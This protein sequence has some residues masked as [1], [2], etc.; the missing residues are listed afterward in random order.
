MTTYAV[1]IE[2]DV[3][4]VAREAGL[5]GLR[6]RIVPAIRGMPGF[7][8]G[9]WLTGNEAGTGSPSREAGTGLSLALWDDQ[10]A[11]QAMAERFATGANP[12]AGT[13]VVR[14]EVREVAAVAGFA[15]TAAQ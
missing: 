8:A 5:E 13:A 4:A 10:L 11:A 14:C 2:V 12:L 15:D 3:A 1:P 6:E 7:R 9:V